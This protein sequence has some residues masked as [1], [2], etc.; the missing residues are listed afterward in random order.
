MWEVL[1]EGEDAQGFVWDWPPGPA[2]GTDPGPWACPPSPSDPLKETL[3]SAVGL[4]E[5][6][7]QERK[8]RAWALEAKKSHP[9]QR[10]DQTPMMICGAKGQGLQLAQ[11]P[12]ALV[13]ALPLWAQ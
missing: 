2:R 8:V 3:T 11:G 9:G 6:G 5:C 10:L 13:R 7:R 1:A 4:H 12:R